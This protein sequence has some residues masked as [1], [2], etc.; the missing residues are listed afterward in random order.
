MVSAHQSM[1]GVA[2]IEK[3]A[4]TL[5]VEHVVKA[6]LQIVSEVSIARGVARRKIGHANK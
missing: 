4:G 3:A 1:S 5:T 2:L 6:A